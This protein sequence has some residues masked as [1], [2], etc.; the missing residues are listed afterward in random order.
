MKRAVGVNGTLSGWKRRV[1]WVDKY[2]GRGC[3]DGKARRSHPSVLLWWRSL[4]GL[5]VFTS[6]GV[7]QCSAVYTVSP[8]T[9]WWMTLTCV[10]GVWTGLVVSNAHTWVT[11][12]R[13]RA[14]VWSDSPLFSHCGKLNVNEQSVWR[15][16]AAGYKSPLQAHTHKHTVISFQNSTQQKYIQGLGH[17]KKSFTHLHAVPNPYD[18]LEHKKEMFHRV[19]K[20]LGYMLW[21]WIVA[22]F[23]SKLCKMMWKIRKTTRFDL[24]CLKMVASMKIGCKIEVKM[25]FVGTVAFFM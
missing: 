12:E 22:V 4:L 24:M 11:W 19:V 20:L 10:Y 9:P 1:E 5:D 17:P 6:A 21:K 3:F 15:L 16:P 18:F 7:M 25:D 13:E 23:T 8:I 2:R 14:G